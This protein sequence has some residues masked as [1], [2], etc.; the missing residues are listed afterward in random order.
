[1]I[2]GFAHPGGGG[3]GGGGSFVT[4]GT[5]ATDPFGGSGPSWNFNGASNALTVDVNTNNL[6]P[7]GSDWCFEG[8]FYQTDSN[9]FPRVFSIGA[10]PS[11]A[12]AISLEGGTMYYWLN[13]GVAAT[14]T[15]PTP[16]TWHHFVFSYNAGTGQTTYY[17]DGVAHTSNTDT[18][19]SIAGQTLVIGAETVA[20]LPNVAFGG[21]MNS[22]RWTVGNSV[23]TG[24]FTVPTSA[25][26]TTQ[27]AG[28][29]INAITSGQV[30]LLM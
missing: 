25:L 26:Q 27:S 19:P 3:G 12:I 30:K 8:F 28:T 22:L 7:A 1:M 5:I 18:L 17:L 11:A 16:N 14:A 23:Y 20:G 4:P 29:N 21:Y 10:Y 15:K 24:D 13:G 9:A 2:A 6:D